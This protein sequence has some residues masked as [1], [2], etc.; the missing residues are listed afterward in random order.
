MNPSKFLD[1]AVKHLPRNCEVMMRIEEERRVVFSRNDRTYFMRAGQ[2][3]GTLELSQ[4]SGIVEGDNS[5]WYLLHAN[6]LNVSIGDVKHMLRPV[7]DE[8]GRD[9]LLWECSIVL[10]VENGQ[11]IR[12]LISDVL[13]HLDAYVDANKRYMEY[14]SSLFDALEEKD[15][16]RFLDRALL[17]DLL[18]WHRELDEKMEKEAGDSEDDKDWEKEEDWAEEDWDEEDD[19]DGYEDDDDDDGEYDDYDDEDDEYDDDEEYDGLDGEEDDDAEWE[20][21]DE[22]G[23]DDEDEDD[24]DNRRPGKRP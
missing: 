13:D 1:Q 16:K 10:Y 21:E 2:Y 5:L 4:I 9:A 11:K 8:E 20:D 23:Y 12:R 22:E 18:Q 6:L 3:S 7:W 19:E 14:L 15:R 17:F 24:D